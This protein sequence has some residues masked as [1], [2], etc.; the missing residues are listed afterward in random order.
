MQI[1]NDNDVNVFLQ[2]GI[3]LGKP[4]EGTKEQLGTTKKNTRNAPTTLQYE[5]NVFG[6]VVQ[7]RS[8]R[9]NQCCQELL[10]MGDG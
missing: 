2:K 6:V 7:R 8:Y 5:K 3:I 9:I 10:E 1:C 4:V